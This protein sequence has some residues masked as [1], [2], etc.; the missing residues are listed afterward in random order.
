MGHHTA[1]TCLICAHQVDVLFAQ[2]ISH[3]LAPIMEYMRK[4]DKAL[5]SR[6]ADVIVMGTSAK[7]AEV[8]FDL[9]LS[10]RQVARLTFSEITLGVMLQ[11]ACDI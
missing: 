2:E 5:H 8:S 9:K 10:A 4:P 11:G 3:H 1:T 6:A 7:P